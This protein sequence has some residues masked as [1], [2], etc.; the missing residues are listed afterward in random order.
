MLKV[1]EFEHGFPVLFSKQSNREYKINDV[2]DLFADD[3]KLLVNILQ[4]H[5]TTQR[6]RLNYLKS[7]YDNQN[8]DIY[9]GVRRLNDN[10]SDNR[11]SHPFASYIAVNI[12]V[13]DINS[14]T[15]VYGLIAGA[16][17]SAISVLLNIK[18]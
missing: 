5:Y 4:D 18:K 10:K 12:M 7:Y 14:K 17:G 3:S 11:A 13:I 8:W 2:K 16:I 1:N 9:H 15:A 6:Q